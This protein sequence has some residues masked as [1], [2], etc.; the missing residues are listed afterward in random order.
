MDKHIVSVI[1]K[2][3]VPSCALVS[4]WGSPA[5]PRATLAS[6]PVNQEQR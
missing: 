6:I 4:A 5:V 1:F 3:A 2:Q